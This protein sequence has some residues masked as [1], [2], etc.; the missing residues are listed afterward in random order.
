M[1]ISYIIIL[2]FAFHATISFCQSNEDYFLIKMTIQSKV[3]GEDLL[4][5]NSE[6]VVN[7]FEKTLEYTE[8]IPV[9]DQDVPYAF[10]YTGYS[11]TKN[12]VTTINFKYKDNP[13]GSSGRIS[14]NVFTN[15]LQIIPPDLAGA[16]RR[17]ALYNIEMAS[18]LIK[19][20]SKEELKK[21]E[22][23]KQKIELQ[24]K[25]SDNKTIKSINDF[26]GQGNVIEA[27]NE[28]SKLNSENLELKQTIQSK[29]DAD[30][31]NDS[32]PTQL[33]AFREIIEKNNDIISKLNDG[34]H[35]YRI[36]K[37]GSFF[38][39][40][41]KVSVLADYLVEQKTFGKFNTK[42]AS[43][44][45]FKL[46]K[47]EQMVYPNGLKDIYDNSVR[48]VIPVSRK[49]NDI[50]ENKGKFYYGKFG[51]PRSAWYVGNYDFN[52][53]KDVIKT[54]KQNNLVLNPIIL[55]STL[56]GK[57]LIQPQFSVSVHISSFDSNMS[58]KLNQIDLAESKVYRTTKEVL[59]KKAI[60]RKII[61]SIGYAAIVP[62][63]IWLLLLE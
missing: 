30:Y 15:L 9:L 11:S 63:V 32:I 55:D 50:Y 23:E 21:E 31:S 47:T 62:V 27:A 25:E 18:S 10:D 53:D 17:G 48:L 8:Y 6:V 20:P 3:S 5:L 26:L 61:K 2:F 51:A 56:T 33:N 34:V 35:K 60:G 16:N 38:I 19:F 58:E 54:K 57:I 4:K 28:Y 24:K 36:E 13:Y 7:T 43:F 40:G 45:S 14:F 41:S 39:D 37:N 52:S 42:I 29:L 44:G 1:K 49:Q 12:G 46:S 22:E 59:P